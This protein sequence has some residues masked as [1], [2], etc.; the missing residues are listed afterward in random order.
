MA[1]IY[2]GSGN[3]LFYHG[4]TLLSG[5]GAK[6]DLDGATSKYYICAISVIVAAKFQVLNILDGGVN[7]GM[8]NTHF[9][10]TEDTQTLDDDW[11]G[12]TAETDDDQ[13]VLTAG[14]GCPEFP[15]GVTIYGMWDNVELHAGTVICYVAPRPDYTSRAASL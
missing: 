10:S 1:S 12:V 2:G 15:I 8:G 4:S 11:G 6:I 13:T 5:D 7:L 3:E 9:V 14:S